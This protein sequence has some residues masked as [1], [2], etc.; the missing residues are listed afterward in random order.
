MLFVLVSTPEAEILE[1]DSAICHPHSMVVCMHKARL[2]AFGVDTHLFWNTSP[3][4][5]SWVAGWL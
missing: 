5:G 1:L 2:L 3:K 4:G